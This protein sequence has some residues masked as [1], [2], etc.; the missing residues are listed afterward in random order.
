MAFSSLCTCRNSSNLKSFS[1]WGQC[2]NVLKSNLFRDRC[3]FFKS[4]HLFK[5]IQPSY[6]PRKNQREII[7]YFE[8]SLKYWKEKCNSV[9]NIANLNISN[10]SL[11]LHLPL[12]NIFFFFQTKKNKMNKFESM[13][14]LSNHHKIIIKNSDY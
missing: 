7:T 10:F 9:K 1:I 12:Y 5:I 11:S 2:K 4:I 13:F 3:N 14:F 6:F 8:L